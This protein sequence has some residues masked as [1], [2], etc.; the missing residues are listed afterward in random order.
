MDKKTYN[1]WSNYATWRVNLELV[2]GVMP[3][4]DGGQIFKDVYELSEYIKND[5]EEYLSIDGNTERHAT[6]CLDYALAFLSDVNWH[7]IAQHIADDNQHI[8]KNYTQLDEYTPNTNYTLGDL[9]DSKNE[10]IKRNAMSI[11]KTL[12]K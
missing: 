11:L 8:I 3:E 10:T 6:I 2:D 12:N 9:L 4:T 1:G 7:E 5:V